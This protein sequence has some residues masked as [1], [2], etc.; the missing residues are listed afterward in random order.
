MVEIR[1]ESGGLDFEASKVPNI[2]PTYSEDGLR[3]YELPLLMIIGHC[4]KEGKKWCFHK[5]QSHLRDQE[6]REFVNAGI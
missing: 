5:A 2:S 3:F 1:T 4:S 6:T